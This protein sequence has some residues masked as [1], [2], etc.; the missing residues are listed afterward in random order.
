MTEHVLM[1]DKP[2]QVLETEDWKKISADCAPPG[3]YTPNMSKD[4][5]LLWKAKIVGTRSGDPRVEIRKT[6]IGAEPYGGSRPERRWTA[7]AQMLMIVW[8]PDNDGRSRVRISLNGT[9]DL[10][11]R[12]YAEMER[13]VD[14]AQNALIG[15]AIDQL[16]D[17]NA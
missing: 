7:Y 5:M 1:W 12:E 2:Q 6:V 8:P 9:A 16:A 13:A 15:L 17:D 10:S 4:D 14:E 11:P 3:V